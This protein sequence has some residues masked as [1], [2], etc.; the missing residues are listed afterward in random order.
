MV[1]N[2]I[3]PRAAIGDY[4]SRHRRLHPLYHEPESARGAPGHLGVR[5]HRARAQAACDRARRWRRFRL[6]DLH[7][8]RG[9]RLSLGL[10]EDRA[11]GQV[12]RRA[13]RELRLRRSGS[14]PCQPRRTGDG[15][16][17]QFHGAPR[18]H[19]RQPRRLSLD[20]LVVRSRPISTA[21][22]SQA[23]TRPPRSIAR[24]MRSTPTPR[25]WTPCAAP[26]DRKPPIWSRPSS[27]KR[28]EE[29]GR[30]PVELRRKNFI[31]KDAFP[32]Q[33]PVALQYDT[34]DYEAH[35]DKALQLA[36][37]AGFPGRR[38]EAEARGKRRGIGLSC[39]IEACGIAPSAVVGSLG[40]GVG[41]WDSAKIRF[42]HTGM[43]QV[44]TGV[45]SH[46]QG[47][48][49]TF[50]QLVADKLGRADRQRRGVPRRHREDAGRH[51]HLRLALARG[52]RPGDRQ[53][54]RED[55]RQGQEDR[56]PPARGFRGRHRVQGRQVHGR[57]HRPVQVAS[58]RWCSRLT[59]RFHYPAG[60]GRAGHGGDGLLRPGQLHLS[61]RHATSARSR[62]TPTPAW[63]RSTRFIA[64]DDFGKRDQ[65]DDRRG[66]GPRRDRPG[67]RPGAAGALRLRRERPAGD[68]RP[69]WTTAC[70]APA[71]CRASRWG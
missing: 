32:Y 7:L 48:E 3:E 65:P 45:H 37:Y 1:T 57:G 47:H 46:G 71:I 62:S 38:A 15:R 51:G 33:T 66:P 34:G 5:R 4:D 28:R 18:P 14:R 64:V 42:S 12:G 54:G 69:S 27:T 35:L 39:Y 8:R 68:R 44:F 30:D 52:R 49:T 24:S 26:G 2:A 6:Q 61:G 56:R 11:A 29:T 40:C 59:C 67:D 22:C 53:R 13:Q 25:R 19:D 9:V 70:R 60:P 41:L 10:E 36:D 20:V 16:G 17:R 31:P 23:S 58:A 50:A 55:R 21:L 63:S 43:V